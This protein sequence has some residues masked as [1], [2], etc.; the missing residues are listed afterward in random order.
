MNIRKITSL[1]ALLSFALLMVTS[2]I[3]YI[4]PAGRV[5]YWSG[6]RLW[7]LSK[8]DWGAVHINLGFLLLL[9]II[10]HTFYNWG[11]LVSYLKNRTKQLK[12]FTPDFSIAL[13]LTLVVFGGTLA[14]LPPMSSII[15]LGTRITDQANLHYGEPPYGHAELSPLADFA[16]KV[17]LDAEQSLQRLHSAG[18]KVD[19]LQQTM[20]DIATANGV[21]PQHLYDLIRPVVANASTGAMPGSAPGGTGNRTLAQLCELYGLDRSMVVSG[22]ASRGISAGPEQT[23]KEIAAANGMDPHAVYAA[24]YEVAGR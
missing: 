19:S 17:K 21:T 9:S 14:G 16:D 2:V 23:I 24:I 10:L 12:I 18:I 20:Q 8:E 5:A 1:T 7:G 13:V 22:L 4:V 3:L 6:W 15:D 11:A